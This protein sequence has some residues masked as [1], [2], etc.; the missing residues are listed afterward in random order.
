MKSVSGY[1]RSKTLVAAVAALNILLAVVAG[2]EGAASHRSA[3]CLDLGAREL[4]TRALARLVVTKDPSS[5]QFINS[6]SPP[7]RL[8]AKLSVIQHNVCTESEKYFSLHV[9]LQ[10]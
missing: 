9:F 8:V 10:H 3:S 2:V 4:M 6:I 1:H 7:F 5:Q